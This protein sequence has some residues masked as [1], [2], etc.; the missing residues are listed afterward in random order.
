MFTDHGRKDSDS[1]EFQQSHFNRQNAVE[2]SQSIET[3]LKCNIEANFSSEVQ[4]EKQ[5][6]TENLP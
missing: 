5:D 4:K 2:N 6:S 1:D 3:L